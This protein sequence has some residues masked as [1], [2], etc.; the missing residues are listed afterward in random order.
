LADGEE[1][2]EKEQEMT[3]RH[4]FFLK[5]FASNEER[6]TAMVGMD[7]RVRCGHCGMTIAGSNS[8]LGPSVES[9]PPVV[10]LWRLKPNVWFG[11]FT[12]LEQG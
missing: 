10:I 2:L 3:C 11:E 8:T 12:V 1:S 5:D 6:I 7:W 4:E 9:Q